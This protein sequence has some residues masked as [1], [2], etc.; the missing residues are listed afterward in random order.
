MNYQHSHYLKNKER[1]NKKHRE[2]YYKN[3]GKR[4]KKIN[5]YQQENHDYLNQKKREYNLTHKEET[6]IRNKKYH[7]ERKKLIHNLKINGC[8]I[9]GYNTYDSCLEF[10]HINPQ[11]KSFNLKAENMSHPSD[12]IINEFYKCILLCKNCHFEIHAKERGEKKNE[13]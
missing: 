9:C 4:T 11:D 7:A 6:K 13:K 1:L 12:K 3:K 2:Y 8:S 5:E 10:H